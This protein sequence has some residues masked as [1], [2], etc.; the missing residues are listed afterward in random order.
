MEAKAIE[1]MEGSDS[2][3]TATSGQPTSS[4]DPVEGKGRARLGFLLGVLPSW[5]S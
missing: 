4:Q 2:D 5:S 1:V 3:A